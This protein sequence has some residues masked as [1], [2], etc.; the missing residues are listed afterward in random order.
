MPG[1]KKEEIISAAHFK[2]LKSYMYNTKI[3]RSENIWRKEYLDFLEDA[4]AMQPKYISKLGPR[5]CNY[6]D[7]L[8]IFK[9]SMLLPMFGREIA[10]FLNGNTHYLHD[11]FSVPMTDKITGVQT[12]IQSF[13]VKG[14]F[15]LF[16]FPRCFYT[17][18]I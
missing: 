5:Y 15:F 7:V 10:Y 3:D 2:D 17:S 14:F 9:E 1:S 18:K 12:I 8:K 4:W 11:D 6:T 16:F 13:T